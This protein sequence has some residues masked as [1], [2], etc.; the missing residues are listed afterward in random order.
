MI[1]FQGYFRSDGTVGVRNHVAVI[2]SVG[3]ANV[4]AERI[5]AAVPGSVAVVHNS[6]CDVPN[7]EPILATLAGTGRNP[8]V[9]AAL[10]V[11]LGCELT[12]AAAV[13]ERIARSGKPTEVLVIQEEGGVRN[14]VAHGV[15]IVSRLV[16]AAASQA[17]RE[18]PLSKLVLATECG[19]SDATSGL[20][21]NPVLGVVSERV[22]SEGGAVV[23]SETTELIGAEH[24][25]AARAVSPEV[26]RRLLDVVASLERQAALSGHDIRTTQPS[27]GNVAGGLTTIEEKSLGCICKVGKSALQ[28]VLSYAQ[29][30]PGAG[31]YFMDT[32]GQDIY[33]V[34]AMVAGGA[35]M[36]A[37]TTGL[38]T[39]IGSPI[40]PVIKIT[41]NP[42][43]ALSMADHIDFSAGALIEGCA[44]VTDLGQALL[45]LLLE[46]ASGR[47]TAAEVLGQREFGIYEGGGLIT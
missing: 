46:V 42:R 8:N 3:C 11:G 36:V 31:L 44:S 38:G 10:V 7:P 6:G 2:S 13:A 43:T 22:I 24:L 23:L 45:L 26:G 33:S 14:T 34:T 27:P 5:A 21:A 41:G 18:A 4:A 39:P 32:P 28:G 29:P 20:V 19:A 12:P 47:L 30:V 40:A 37:F 35:Q 1:T 16:S 17:R 9:A 25:L 15:E